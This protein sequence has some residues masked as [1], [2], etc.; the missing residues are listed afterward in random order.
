MNFATLA[1]V[2]LA[3]TRLRRMGF[4]GL[5]QY[6]SQQPLDFNELLQAA[7]LVMVG[8]VLMDQM[9]LGDITNTFKRRRLN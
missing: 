2:M 4:G 6:G 1:M 9:P 7:G 8:G 3:I 5:N